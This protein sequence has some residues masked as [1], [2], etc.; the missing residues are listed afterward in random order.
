MKHEITR[1]IFAIKMQKRLVL[2]R[3]G[4]ARYLRKKKTKDNMQVKRIKKVWKGTRSTRYMSVYFK[5][6]YV[7]THREALYIP[8]TCKNTIL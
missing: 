6:E 2:Y 5:N 1:K 7:L 3:R 8:C 4:K